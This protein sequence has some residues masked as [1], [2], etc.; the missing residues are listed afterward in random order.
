MGIIY[1]GIY[2]YL[3]IYYIYIGNGQR[4]AI[5]DA[6]VF[7]LMENITKYVFSG[8]NILACILA[9]GVTIVGFRYCRAKG[10]TYVLKRFVCLYVIGIVIFL[11]LI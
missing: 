10:T 1:G 9:A 5:I 11:S 6:P 8:F 2:G 3:G 4:T 7:L